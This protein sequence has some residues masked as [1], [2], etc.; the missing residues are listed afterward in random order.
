MV[1]EEKLLFVIKDEFLEI[2][3]KYLD[4]RRIKIEKVFNE[5]DIEDFI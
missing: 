5:I 4:E 3:V 2:K 1:S